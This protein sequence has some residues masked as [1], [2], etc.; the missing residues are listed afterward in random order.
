MCAIWTLTILSSDALTLCK[1]SLP[2]FFTWQTVTVFLPSLL[3]QH[4]AMQMDALGLMGL[5]K[6]CTTKSDTSPS[7]LWQIHPGQLLCRTFGLQS[8]VKT[9]GFS[10]QNDFLTSIVRSAVYV[11]QKRSRLL[12][13][14]LWKWLLWTS[15][16][17]YTFRYLL[18]FYT[19]S[20]QRKNESILAKQ[21]I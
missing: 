8:N 20:S 10:L 2:L 12:A 4:C 14:G 21:E 16:S 19:P 18:M 6:P 3:W 1:L 13:L 15:R 9:T 17:L 11:L 5:C 7:L